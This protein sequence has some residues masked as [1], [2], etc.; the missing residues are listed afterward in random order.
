M[1]RWAVRVYALPPPAHDVDRTKS[2][3]LL[4][5]L[6]GWGAAARRRVAIDS[7]GQRR[8]EHP[9]TAV[10]GRRE[11]FREGRVE[12]RHVPVGRGVLAGPMGR[13]G[14]HAEPLAHARHVRGI[15]GQRREQIEVHDRDA[16]GIRGRDRIAGA[17]YERWIGVGGVHH[18]KG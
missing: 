11:C 3:T 13:P 12:H 6:N 14:V 10:H 15:V 5:V 7:R 2:D 1:G 9:T 18:E 17:V 8:R 4:R 16:E